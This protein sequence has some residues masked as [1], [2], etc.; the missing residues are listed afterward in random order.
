MLQDWPH[1]AGAEAVQ[2]RE[3]FNRLTSQSAAD[4]EAYAI[5]LFQW[6]AQRVPVYKAY[7]Q[8]LK[9]KPESIHRLAD[10]PTL[11]LSFF[12]SHRVQSWDFEAAATFTSST[13]TGQIPA[14]HAVSDLSFYE[15]HSQRLFEANYGPVSD[16]VVLALLPSYLERGGSSLVY[17]AE[18]FIRSGAQAESGFFLYDFAALHN[19]YEQAKQAGKQ[20]LLLGVSYALLDLAESPLRMQLQ[21]DDVLMETGGMKGRRRELVR[22]ELH[23]ILQEAFGVSAVHS[24]YGMTELLSQAYSKGNGIYQKAPTL[25]LNIRDVN[26]PFS[27]LAPGKTGGVNLIDLANIDSCAF[28]QTQDLGRLHTDGSFEIL[29]R[30]DNSELRGCNLMV[31]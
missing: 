22:E 4:W 8:A 19:S 6:Q 2:F 10:I 29:G 30:F 26:D 25:L 20:V 28:L 27:L 24:E 13:T 16:W 5:D 14:K 1:E 11:P 23:S 12:K 7:L 31:S 18:H 9:I 3:R 15:Q 17:M 21:A